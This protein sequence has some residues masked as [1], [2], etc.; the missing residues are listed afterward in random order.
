MQN[1][2]QET[3]EAGEALTRVSVFSHA[4]DI[5]GLLYL[6]HR[7][8]AEYDEASMTTSSAL[9]VIDSVFSPIQPVLGGCS[10]SHVLASVV[11]WG[12]AD[13]DVLVLGCV[14]L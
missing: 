7:L 8:R 12:V 1:L 6:L 5:H 9:L 11:F 14:M 10:G 13:G 3:E 2:Q 4:L